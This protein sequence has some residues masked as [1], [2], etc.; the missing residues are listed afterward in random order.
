[1]DFKPG[2][3]RVLIEPVEQ[4]EKTLGGV[5]LPDTAKE[6]PVN[7]KVLAVGPGRTLES[8]TVVPIAYKV[9]DT[10]AY[11]KYSGTELKIEGKDYIVISEKDILGAFGAVKAGVN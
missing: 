10:V 8:G 2:T 1:M 6:K 4:A 7:G 11:S 3:D 5:F 9:G